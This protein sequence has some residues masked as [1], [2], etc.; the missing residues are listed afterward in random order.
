[1]IPNYASIKPQT[2][3][4][5]L[6][7]IIQEGAPL[8]R[9]T[10][11]V[12]SRYHTSRYTVADE[13]SNKTSVAL[14]SDLITNGGTLPFDG[15]PANTTVDHDFTKLYGENLSAVLASYT[16]DFRVESLS[17]PNVLVAQGFDVAGGSLDSAFRGKAPAAG[18]RVRVSHDGKTV[19]RVILESTKVLANSSFG[20]NDD[21]DNGQAGAGTVPAT[22]ATSSSAGVSAPGGL[23]LAIVDTDDWSGFS[24]GSLYDGKYGELYT[25]TVLSDTVGG[26]TVVRVT[27]FS[28]A[29]SG[30]ITF[31]WDP[32]ESVHEVTSG[33]LGGL[34]LT[35]AGASALSTGQVFSFEIYGAYS[36][37]LTNATASSR[38]L[39]I[40]GLYDGKQD[41]TYLIRVVQA[42]SN[43]ALAGTVL[44]ISDTGG[45]DGS[46]MVTVSASGS[47]YALGSKGLLFSFTDSGSFEGLRKGDVFTVQTLAAARTG[48]DRVLIL[49]GPAVDVSGWADAT[50]DIDTVEFVHTFTGEVTPRRNTAPVEAF[51]S[52][53]AGVVLQPSLALYVDGRN[54]GFKWVTAESR[55]TSRI[56]VHYRARILPTEDGEL[57]AVDTV[58]DELQHAGVNDY[59]NPLGKATH[60][61]RAGA[62]GRSVLI[63]PVREETVQGYTDALRQTAWRHEAY[64]FV[65]L[66]TDEDIQSAVRNIVYDNSA[67]EVRRFKRAYAAVDTPFTSPIMTKVGEGAVLATISAGDDGNNLVTVTN[68]GVDLTGELIRPGHVVRYSYSANEWGD[69]VYSTATVREVLSSNEIMLKSGI[70]APV[71]PA[72]KI[73]IWAPT[74]AE[75]QTDALV[76]RYSSLN[77]RRMP[78]VWSDTPRDGNNTL[79]SSIY[80][81]AHIG[82]LRSAILP[83]QPLTD[84][85]ITIASSARGMFARFTTEQLDRIAAAGAFIVTQDNPVGPVYVRHQ[86]TTETDKGPLYY[87]DSIGVNMDDISFEMDDIVSQYR[88]R[89]QATQDLADV[90]Q[91]RIDTA[92]RDR[93]FVPVDTPLLGPALADYRDLVVR[94][95][96]VIRS[97][98]I[99]EVTLVFALPF[100]QVEVRLRGTVDQ[101]A[102]GIVTEL[103]FITT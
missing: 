36:V 35:I 16:E 76:R 101:E 73:E 58:A 19:E 44:Q 24:E 43:G 89:Y 100:N 63:A 25:L 12:G 7:D 32:G 94:I 11:L 93:T 72:S 66:T 87:E 28:G 86:L 46:S 6:L 103:A 56:F 38:N 62:Q 14:T 71:T 70:S 79:F 21:R 17:T 30:D 77:A 65:P 40:T 80:L 54:A 23:T 3:I 8:P 10:V 60:V 42:N 37:D 99:I 85:E 69:D 33:T 92:L 83:Q 1:M 59:D 74:T 81:A 57:I 18:D 68:E 45:F 61:A 47:T 88:G 52:T 96:P 102:G 5:Q 82:G 91:S 55:P 64:I 27:S 75:F 2:V 29:F 13:K 95:D 4:R 51:E 90:L 50:T 15:R 31:V 20:S 26:E 97:K 98:I 48:A 67:P 9:Q 34:S 41:T 39:Q 22:A 49:S 78:M 84:T 53:D